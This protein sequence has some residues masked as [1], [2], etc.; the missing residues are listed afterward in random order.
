MAAILLPDV[1]W[2]SDS[3]K[4]IG[5]ASFTKYS[6]CSTG[7]QQYQQAC[8]LRS[9]SR[10]TP[11]Q[12]PIGPTRTCIYSKGESRLIE[13]NLTLQSTQHSHLLGLLSRKKRKF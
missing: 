2:Q 11:A 13:Q 1:M 6:S 9:L 4:G 12:Y 5:K 7:C 3:L 8:L 10:P